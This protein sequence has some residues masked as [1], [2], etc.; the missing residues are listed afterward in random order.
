MIDES[1]KNSLGPEV[2]SCVCDPSIWIPS[3]CFCKLSRTIQT[4][5]KSISCLFSKWLRNSQPEKFLNS[6]GAK[7]Q[8]FVGYEQL[9]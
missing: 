1:T 3:A 4:K 5:H 9:F 6:F 2:M 7:R 8:E